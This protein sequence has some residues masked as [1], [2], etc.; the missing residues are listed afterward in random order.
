MPEMVETM[1][2]FYGHDDTFTCLYPPDDLSPFV[3]FAK[4]NT[5]IIHARLMS[6]E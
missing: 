3:K 2:V 1:I 4:S 5:G 6:I